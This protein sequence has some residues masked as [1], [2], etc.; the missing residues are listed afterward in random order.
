M[1]ADFTAHLVGQDLANR[2]VTAYT[3]HVRLFATWF[4]LTNGEPLDKTNITAVD[5]REYRQHLTQRGAAPATINTKL[6]ALKAFATWC[7]ITLQV[8]GIE[9]QQLAPRWL[10]PQEQSALLREAERAINAATSD[11]GRALATR[12][13]AL[14][15]FLLNTGLR[16][17]ELRAISDV[18]MGP[19][20]GSMKVNGKGGKFRC[21]A[22]NKE[23]RAALQ[24]LGQCLDLQPTSVQRAIGELGRRAGVEVT[25]HILRHTF[26]HNL[27]GRVPLDRIAAL[28]GHSDIQ[29]TRRY[30]TPGQQDLQAAV[31]TLE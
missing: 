7:G 28:L 17:S 13:R 24:A 3:D 6:A 20:S 19:R 4:E 1:L 9:Q 16:V 26:A 2:T 11:H 5:A 10:K 12:N 27:S 14:I 30:T 22:L 15:V 21:V 29:T 18:S 8:T 31:E 23:A 25:P